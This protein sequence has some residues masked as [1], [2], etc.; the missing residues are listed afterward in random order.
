[1][2]LQGPSSAY[3][4]RI[5]VEGHLDPS[6]SSRLGGMAIE[7]SPEGEEAPVSTLTGP[8]PD[9]CALSGVLNALVDRWHAVVSVQ[10]LPGG[11]GPLDP[12]PDEEENHEEA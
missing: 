4:Y 9:Q 1:M 11:E 7:L 6:W 2:R 12:R 10:R 5:R 3:T 8:L